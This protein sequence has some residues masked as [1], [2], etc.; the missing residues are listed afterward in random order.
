MD[1]SC[2]DIG[3]YIFRMSIPYPDPLLPDFPDG[4][5]GPGFVIAAKNAPGEPGRIAVT[6]HA[7]GRSPEGF[8]S[9]SVGDEIT[10]EGYTIKITS[11]C[12]KEAR[13]DLVKQP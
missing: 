11:I 13:F 2:T 9:I 8:Y 5:P 10:Y 12:E 1:S 7:T 3:K 6:A 4:S